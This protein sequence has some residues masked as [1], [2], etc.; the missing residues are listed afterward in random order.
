MSIGCGR[1]TANP[2]AVSA[3]PS[4]LTNVAILCWLPFQCRMLL[5]PSWMQL[6]FWTPVGTLRFAPTGHTSSLEQL[7][8]S[9]TFCC[10]HKRERS[11]LS[12]RLGLILVN[13]L[14]FNLRVIIIVLSDYRSTLAAVGEAA[15]GRPRCR[16]IARVTQ[17]LRPF[18]QPSGR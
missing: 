14:S 2:I 7:W 8:Y 10:E 12:H 4:V 15:G 18:D 17:Q 11:E 9:Q 6:T 13:R 16:W 1:R 3:L 5:Q